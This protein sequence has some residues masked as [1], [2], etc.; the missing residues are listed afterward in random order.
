MPTLLMGSIVMPTR[1]FEG[2]ISIDDG[3]IASIEEG[4]SPIIEESELVYDFRGCYLMPGLIETHG[5]MRE[6]GLEY[7]E[8]IPH[9]TRAALAGG[10]TTVLDMPN[11]RPP[12]TTV[13]RLHEQIGRYA[14]RAYTDFGINMGVSL[15]DID[16]L[17]EVDPALITGVKLFAAGHAT[18]TTTISRVSDIA[19][20]FEILGERGIIALV[21]AENQE[22]VDF[23]T[24]K[25]RELGR[26]DPAAWSEARNEAVVLTSVLEMIALAKQFGVKLY[27]LH[28]STPEEFAAIAF[29]RQIG[30]NVYGEVTTVHL[31]FNTIDYARF[32]NLINISPALRSPTAQDALWELLR[33]GKIDTV[34]TDHAPHALAEKQKTSAWEVASGM[35][36]MQ[37]ALPVLITNWI[38]R[39][40]S[41][42][43][44]EG[45]IRVSQVTSHN[46]AR[47][48]G[49]TQ[50]GQFSP[51]CDADIVVVDANRAWTVRKAD[52]FTKNQWS[53]YEGMELRG[54]PI[55]TFLR[56][57]LVYKEGEII[58]P[59]RGKHITRK[60]SDQC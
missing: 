20:V 51:G 35:P 54:R 34:V 52:L 24:R 7:K 45:L 10:Y 42:T 39:F 44:A 40:G 60:G 59:P 29:G 22:L 49:L 31:A 3:K 28:Q 38:R 30:V 43:L 18:A 56:G 25:Y 32:G 16:E 14:G 6:P 46:I 4:F 15:E 36:G 50:K 47:F 23:F 1:V 12:T 26:D 2:S 48:F 5:H 55:A 21:H 53:V 8:D 37:E 33:H 41:E 57:Q 17:R 27:L 13:A 9:G 11:T 19:R 58:G